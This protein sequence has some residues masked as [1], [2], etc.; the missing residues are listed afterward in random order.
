[1]T[2][3]SHLPFWRFLDPTATDGDYPSQTFGRPSDRQQ[4]RR[5]EAW[6]YSPSTSDAPAADA[7]TAAEHRWLVDGWAA[8]DDAPA[9]RGHYQSCGM[10]LRDAAQLARQVVTSW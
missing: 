10:V 2:V 4:W 1:M 5:D 3:S 9:L 6:P 8:A 7:F